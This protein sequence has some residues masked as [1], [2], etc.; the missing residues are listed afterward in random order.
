MWGEQLTSGWA[1]R[2]QCPNFMYADLISASDSD[3]ADGMGDF[4][5]FS[6]RPI[7]VQRTDGVEVERNRGV[8]SYLM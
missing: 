8:A 2:R 4:S 1:A 3:R 6:V 7:A 5:N